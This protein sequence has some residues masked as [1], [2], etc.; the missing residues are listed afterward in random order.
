MSNQERPN[1]PTPA[2]TDRES[3][4]VELRGREQRI[5]ALRAR[6]VD[7]EVERIVAG[8]ELRTARPGAGSEIS[9]GEASAVVDALDRLR[10]LESRRAAHLAFAGAGAVSPEELLERMRAGDD[11]LGAWLDA[12]RE[13]A[14]TRGMRIAKLGL[15]LACLAFL[16][17]AFAVHLAFL[18]LLVPVGGAMSF[19]LWTGQ[20]RAWRRVGARRRFE[21][22]PL[23]R[24]VAWTE[25][26]VRTR[27]RALSLAAEG[28][29]QRGTDAGSEDDDGCAEFRPDD[30]EIARSDLR[31]ALAAARIAGESIDESTETRL[32]ALARAWRAGQ[33]LQGVTQDMAGER[34]GADAIRESVY[35]EL[36]RAG[37]A[38]PDGDASVDALEE[39]GADRVRRR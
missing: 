22:L 26:A 5:R 37:A 29:R 17:L 31:E 1:G 36:V 28:L 7:L 8:A 32:R 13:R 18:V 38:P 24:P 25:D 23:E 34:A 20:D 35:R 33:A 11:A 16:A 14:Q 4:L 6:R 9:G 2:T 27:R 12:G 21:S 15:L 3:Q 19:L 30:L 10:V 39:A